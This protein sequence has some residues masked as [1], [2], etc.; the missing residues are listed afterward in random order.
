MTCHLNTG[1]R[2]DI[3]SEK[4]AATLLA[5]LFRILLFADQSEKQ[6]QKLFIDTANERILYMFI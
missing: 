5:E 6:Y 2:E 3:S 1:A 4:N